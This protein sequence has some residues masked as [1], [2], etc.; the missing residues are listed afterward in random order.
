MSKKI[1]ILY[2]RTALDASDYYRGTNAL[3]DL[4][5]LG[6]VNIRIVS[7]KSWDET[8]IYWSD[9]VYFQRPC[10]GEQCHVMNVTKGLNRLVWCDWDDDLINIPPWNP[11]YNYYQN[12]DPYRMIFNSI[13][14]SDLVV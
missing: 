12:I 10:S 7:L 3:S 11:S 9:I 2:I 4:E 5:K 13:C 14:L 1:N 8:D 6:E